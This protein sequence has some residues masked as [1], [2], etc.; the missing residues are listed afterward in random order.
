MTTTIKRTGIVLGSILAAGSIAACTSS[1]TTGPTVTS[2][3]V[4]SGSSAPPST[5]PTNA[6]SSATR[7]DQSDKVL[8]YRLPADA[9][10]ATSTGSTFKPAV[11]LHIV[12]LTAT[13]DSTL[14][15]FYLTSSTS[16]EVTGDF[17]DWASMPSFTDPASKTEYKVNTYKRKDATSTDEGGYRCVCS[18]V[19]EAGGTS[20]K[21]IYTAQYP[22]LPSGI[23]T[24]RLTDPR[25]TKVDVPVS[26]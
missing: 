1:S 6:P 12:S 23:G 7:T 24:V 2:A 9:A 15:T 26:R 25:F 16:N 11:T 22:A 10:T 5:G 4:T 17:L 20:D 3:A 8:G 13:S 19:T 14:L 18:R 21:V